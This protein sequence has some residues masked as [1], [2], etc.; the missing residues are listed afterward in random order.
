MCSFEAFI[1]DKHVVGKVKEKDA[2]K[3]EYKAAVQ[4]GAG[5]N[6]NTILLLLIII[7]DK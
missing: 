6:N 5:T 1:G 2:A 3:K 7:I 4:R